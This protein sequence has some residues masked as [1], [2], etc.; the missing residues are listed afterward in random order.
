MDTPTLL[1]I[2]GI[3]GDLSKRK[4]LPA[5]GEMAA[6]GVLPKKFRII[7]VTRQQAVTLDN[8]LQGVKNVERIRSQIELFPMSL[9]AGKDYTRLAAHLREIGQTLGDAPQC[10]WYLAVPPKTAWPIIEHLNVSGLTKVPRT[11]LLLEKPFGV[12]RESAQELITH[13]E[14]SFAPEQV[15]RIDHY[16]AKETVQNIVVFRR[17]NPLFERT[18]NRDSIERIDIIASETIGIEGR[19]AFYEQTGA[20]RDIVQSHLLQL[21]ALTLMTLPAEGEW[22]S[23]PEAR[24]AL[25]RSLEVAPDR[26]HRGQYAGYRDEVKNPS[27]VVE[28]FASLTLFSNDPR[29]KDVPITLTT[30][31]A[32]AQKKTEIIVTYRRNGSPEANLLTLRLQPNEGV[33]LCFFAKRP[34][35]EHK[36]ERVPLSFTY[37]G[38]FGALPDAY[39]HVFLDAVRG[40]HTLFVSSEE[41]LES[42]RIIDAVREAWEPHPDTLTLYPRCS[43]P[44]QVLGVEKK[45][46]C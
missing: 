3:T 25:L 7:G 43:T 4:L 1:I 37:A 17:D 41:V 18:W 44:E 35:Y 12:D 26:V 5:L 39:E 42:W 2:V 46:R 45:N 27:S 32:L 6:A 36:I 30:G 24:L 11:K 38:H 19:A 21:A 8:L 23:I 31:K 16:L 29:W 15:Y 14:Q 22:Q 20:L 33:E 34:G 40:D 9:T 10:L 28:T 13:V